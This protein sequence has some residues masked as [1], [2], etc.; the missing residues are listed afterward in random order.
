[1]QF[2]P[3]SKFVF[4]LETLNTPEIVDSVSDIVQR[5]LI[6]KDCGFISYLRNNYTCIYRLDRYIQ[7]LFFALQIQ[8]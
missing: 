8:M 5:M 1:M 4:K 2:D 6:K 7:L 3:V